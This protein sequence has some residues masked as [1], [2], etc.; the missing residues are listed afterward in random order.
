MQSLAR[1]LLPVDFSERSASA[2]RYARPLAV[3]FHSELILLHVLTPASLESGAIG[4]EGSRIRELYEDRSRS[5]ARA[6]N[7][8]LPE[9]LEGLDVQRAVAEGEPSA[10]ILEFAHREGCGLIMMPTHGFGQFRRLILGSNTA[11]VLHGADCPVWTGVHLAEPSRAFT[12]VRHI[13]CA[14]DLGEQSAKALCWASFLARE[15][16][17]ALTVMHVA[18]S[19]PG[20]ESSKAM[21]YVAAGELERLLASEN[22]RAELRIDTGDPAHAICA[23]AAKLDAEVL[24][25]GRGSAGGVYGRLRTNAHAIIRES[26]CPVVSV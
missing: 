17:A 5:A 20:V 18:S 11:A 26:P 23:A 16:G 1:I 2:V 21:V 24:V 3:H 19:A 8:F 7:E 10:Q 25:I 6:L 9:E 12:P 14:V 4:I 22:T 13:L 15:F